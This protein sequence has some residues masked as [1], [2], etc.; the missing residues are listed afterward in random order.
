MLGTWHGKMRRCDGPGEAV[1]IGGGYQFLWLT[2]TSNRAMSCRK[3]LRSAWGRSNRIITSSTLFRLISA[4]RS[5]TVHP[6]ISSWG[7]GE[8]ARWAAMAATRYANTGRFSNRSVCATV[9]IRSTNRQPAS[10]W[11]PYEFFRNNI[12][13]RRIRSVWLFVGSTS[14]L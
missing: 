8:S 4:W 11:Q 5:V 6:R 13:V 10:L 2:S 14:F 7:M 1:C 12:P 9:K 3:T